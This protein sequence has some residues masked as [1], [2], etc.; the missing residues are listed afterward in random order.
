MVRVDYIAKRKDYKT[1]IYIIG[2]YAR[3]GGI[4]LVELNMLEKELLN[5]I[6]WKLSCSGS[7][8]Q[9]YYSSLISYRST[10]SSSSQAGKIQGKQ[11]VTSKENPLQIQKT[12]S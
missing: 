8:L 11:D 7:L 9:H 12:S 3:V 1:D 5:I 10:S 4:S 2:H 6:D